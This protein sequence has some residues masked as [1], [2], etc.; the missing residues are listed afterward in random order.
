MMSS[1]RSLHRQSIIMKNQLIFKPV[2][3]NQLHSQGRERLKQSPLRNL[4]AKPAGTNDGFD[5]LRGQGNM[6]KTMR[7]MC[8]HG[9][10]G[11]VNADMNK[12]ATSESI[13]HFPQ[14]FEV[15]LNALQSSP[16]N[17]Q[18]QYRSRNL[19]QEPQLKESSSV[20]YKF[21]CR[22]ISTAGSKGRKLVKKDQ[23]SKYRA[24]RI[25]G[26]QFN[27]TINEFR[28]GQPMRS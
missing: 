23:G 14:T 11:S 7:E 15:T 17:Q 26:D 24:K 21:P 10:I 25:A 5:T 9:E 16:H 4:L 1:L 12:T 13:Y 8:G 28:P 20:Y 22:Q 19:I 6:F 27:R 2:L 3:R 18:L